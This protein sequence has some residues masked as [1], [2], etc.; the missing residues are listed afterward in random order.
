MSTLYTH[1]YTSTPSSDCSSGAWPSWQTRISRFECP[2][3]ESCDGRCEFSTPLA[4]RQSIAAH[5]CEVDRSKRS[6]GINGNNASGVAP[7]RFT[8][9]IHHNN[10]E[11]L[12]SNPG[13]RITHHIEPVHKG[14]KSRRSSEEERLKTRLLHHDCI[15]PN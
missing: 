9:W 8:L 13:S 12:G 3:F 14:T 10:P 4:Q 11:V 7:V 1:Y 2:E 6:G 5:N 15:S